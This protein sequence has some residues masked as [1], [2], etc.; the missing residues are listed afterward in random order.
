MAEVFEGW[1]I[2]ELMGHRR[3]AG[4]VQEQELAGAAFLRIDVP[5]SVTGDPLQDESEATQF[6]APGAVYCLTPC[7][8]E[9]AREL[10][11]SQR[12]RPVNEWDLPRRPALVPAPG[13]GDDDE[14][15]DLF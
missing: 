5:A 13:D 8:E 12:P 4:Y 11:R 10:A 2:L 9:L 3:L 6:Y 15:R 1:A 7:S 14:E